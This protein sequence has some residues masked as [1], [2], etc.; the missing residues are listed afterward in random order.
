ML[1]HKIGVLWAP[2]HPP[3]LNFCSSSNKAKPEAM[4]EMRGN[5]S[6]GTCLDLTNKL[7]WS[8]LAVPTQLIELWWNFSPCLWWLKDGTFHLCLFYL[9]SFWNQSKR[10]WYYDSSTLGTQALF[11]YVVPHLGSTIVPSHRTLYRLNMWSS[12]VRR[13]GTTQV[14]YI[15]KL[16]DGPKRVKK[17]FSMILERVFEMIWWRGTKWDHTEKDFWR[18]SIFLLSKW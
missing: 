6:A 17:I 11:W 4:Q 15:A 7:M 3:S 1:V 12:W 18:W 5:T 10:I 14:L 16:K 9:A 8:Y 2:T 13:K